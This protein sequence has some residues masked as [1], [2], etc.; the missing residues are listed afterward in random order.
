MI[1]IN[2]LKLRVLEPTE[3]LKPR[4]LKLL[5]LREDQLRSFTIERRSIDARKKPD[6]FFTYTVAVETAIKDEKSF[7][8]HL[9]NNDVTYADKIVYQ[10]PRISSAVIS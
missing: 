5:G 8:L 7:V 2:Q 6:I 10:E 9:R 3:R 4:V 1:K